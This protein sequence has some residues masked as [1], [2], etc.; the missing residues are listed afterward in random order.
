MKTAKH[1]SSEGEKSRDRIVII[2]L[3][4]GKN[5][6]LARICPSSATVL[7]VTKSE[8]RILAYQQT[9]HIS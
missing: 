2:V 4:F 1:I 3:P 7:K 6:L 9:R 5:I 8:A